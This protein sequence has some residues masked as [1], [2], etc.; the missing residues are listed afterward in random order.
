MRIPV[1]GAPFSIPNPADRMFFTRE[2]WFSRGCTPFVKR[3]RSPMVKRPT[4]YTD[5]RRP[6]SFRAMVARDLTQAKA[7][8][9]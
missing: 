8:K 3:G 4:H 5:F 9:R 6:F 1:S 2:H 7:H